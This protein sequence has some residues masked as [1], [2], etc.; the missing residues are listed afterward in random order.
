MWIRSLQH[1]NQK[2]H[3]ESHHGQ[4][5]IRGGGDGSDHPPPP[6][7]VLILKTYAECAWNGLTGADHTGNVQGGGAC[8]WMSK[9]SHTPP[10]RNSCIRAWWVPIRLS[11]NVM[12][13]YQ[14]SR[15][16]SLSGVTAWITIGE[17]TLRHC[18][19][20]W[21]FNILYELACSSLHVLNI[22]KH[23]GR[24]TTSMALHDS[25]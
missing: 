14:E 15:H 23:Q 5:R 8:L 1:F 17:S 6:E 12:G 7:L 3:Q 20:V 9:T 11:V 19:H 16:G 21:W 18:C 25:C 13:H 24:T 10:F 2:L 22:K 4:W